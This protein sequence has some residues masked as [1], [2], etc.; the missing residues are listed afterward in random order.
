MIVF[1]YNFNKSI[2]IIKKKHIN[3]KTS[4]NEFLKAYTHIYFL[5]LKT[6][7]GHNL[8]DFKALMN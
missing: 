1:V 3:F 6:I 2:F 5:L 8:K 4:N 7:F